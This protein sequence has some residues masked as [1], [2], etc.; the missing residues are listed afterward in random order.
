MLKTIIKQIYNNVYIL[1]IINNTVTMIMLIIHL[2]EFSAM[3]I[4]FKD[5]LSTPA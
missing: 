3:E 1:F 2:M 4:L 5:F